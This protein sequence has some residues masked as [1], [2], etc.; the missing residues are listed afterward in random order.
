M[1]YAHTKDI[2]QNE[3]I[4]LM[5]GVVTITTTRHIELFAHMI[6][7]ILLVFRILTVVENFSP[8]PHFGGHTRS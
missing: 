7:A 6:G 4:G 2:R 3:D 8:P 5:V 1:H